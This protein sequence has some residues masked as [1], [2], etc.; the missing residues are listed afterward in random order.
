MEFSCKFCL[1]FQILFSWLQYSVQFQHNSA[2]LQTSS[3]HSKYQSCETFHSTNPNLFS[4]HIT[5]F[6][7]LVKYAS[8]DPYTELPSS[9]R[10][11]SPR[12]PR[13]TSNRA[14][15]PNRQNNNQRGGR[16]SS[17]PVK[18]WNPGEKWWLKDVER[19][20]LD[21]IGEHAPW[22]AAKD[23]TI[24]DNLRTI[25]LSEQKIEL[26]KR[27]LSFSDEE[28]QDEDVLKAKIEKMLHIYSMDDRGF[29]AADVN[30]VEEG[31]L[32]SC[33]PEVYEDPSFL[34]N[35]QAS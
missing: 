30:E 27:G 22:W 20:N 35:E 7:L 10:P 11:R 17:K 31:E 3:R 16:R 13:A 28:C 33:Y 6:D 24:N 18:Q 4:N 9:K 5:Y 32:P 2:L 19:Y 23:T 29:Q 12:K 8:D 25:S 26:E 1:F 21:V 15:R 14:P 34:S